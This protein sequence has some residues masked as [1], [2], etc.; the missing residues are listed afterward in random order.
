LSKTTLPSFRYVEYT[1]EDASD[2]LVTLIMNLAH[3]NG[4][5]EGEV[6]EGGSETEIKDTAERVIGFV[7]N[8]DK[9]E[10]EDE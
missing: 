3:P 5:P 7:P 9:E 1:G 10:E 8:P 2:V 6:H 4:A